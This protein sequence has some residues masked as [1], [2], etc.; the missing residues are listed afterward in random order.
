MKPSPSERGRKVASTV[1]LSLLLFSAVI[2]AIIVSIPVGGTTPFVSND[3]RVDPAYTNAKVASTTA[4]Y[5]IRFTAQ[6]TGTITKISTYMGAVVGHPGLVVAIYSDDGSSNH[7]PSALL[8]LVTGGVVKPVANSFAVG[9]SGA[10]KNQWTLGT[11]VS[12]T[13]GTIYH[14]IIYSNNATASN[15]FYAPRWYP[16]NTVWINGTSN[17]N[18]GVLYSSNSGSS[19]T[20]YSSPSMEAP[21]SLLMTVGSNTNVREGNG[22]ATG[23]T[24]PVHIWGASGGVSLKQG[25]VFYVSAAMSPVAFNQISLVLAK[26]GTPADN[27]YG[28]IYSVTPSPPYAEG[29]NLTLGADL[30]DFTVAT[31]TT[32]L[33][34]CCNFGG[35]VSV[36]PAYYTASFTATTLTTGEYVFYLDSPGSTNTAYYS[37]L[38]SNGQGSDIGT[39]GTLYDGRLTYMADTSA[40][41]ANTRANL[42]P[43]VQLGID[44]PFVFGTT[45]PGTTTTSA[46][47][48]TTSSS[49]TTTT[50]SSSTTTSGTGTPPV[51]SLDPTSGSSGTTVTWAGSGFTHSGSV[52]VTVTFDGAV[53]NPPTSGA[54]AVSGTNPDEMDCHGTATSSGTAGPAAGVLAAIL[55]GRTTLSF[56]LYALD[57]ATGLDSNV[58]TFTVGATTTT[59][60]TGTTTTTTTTTTA[61]SQDSIGYIGCSETWMSVGLPTGYG[62]HAV[63]TKNLLW[64]QLAQYSGGYIGPGDKGWSNATN[65]MWTVFSNEI[66]AWGMPQ[67]VWVEA[68][69]V[70]GPDGVTIANATYAMQTF[71]QFFSILRSKVPT[72]PIYL[73]MINN[74][75]QWSPPLCARMTLSQYDT[76]DSYINHQVSIGNAYAGPVMGPL[77]ATTILTGS[78]CHPNPAGQ[79]LLGAQ[80]VQFFD[81]NW[82]PPPPANTAFISNPF[83]VNPTAT[84]TK[85]TSSSTWYDYRFTAQHSGTV[86]KASTYMTAA[87]GTGITMT[88]YS[89]DGTA[90]HYPDAALCTGTLK[91]TNANGAYAF[92][93]GSTGYQWTLGSCP[94]ITAGDIYHL[95]VSSSNASSTYFWYAR[96]YPQ[97][98][99]WVNGTSNPHRGVLVSS[100]SGSSWSAVTLGGKQSEPVYSLLF[101]NNVVEGNGYAGAATDQ[102]NAEFISGGYGGVSFKQGFTFYISG[103]M[104]PVTFDKISLVI[105]RIGTPA[106]NLYGH[107]YAITTATPYH[108]GQVLS[109]GTDYADF[110]ISGPNTTASLPT[111]PGGNNGC[112]YGSSTTTFPAWRNATFPETTL[113][114]GEYVFYLDSPGSNYATGAYALL[115]TDG[116]GADMSTAGTYFDGR[117]TYGA[118]DQSMFIAN[119]S[120][121]SAVL[122]V[123]KGVDVPFILSS[124][125]AVTVP[126]T[127][128]TANSAPG[129]HIMVSASS[130][131]VDNA[132]IAY[133]KCNGVTVDHSVSPSVTLTAN[134][135]TDTS[136]TRFRFLVSGSP[137]QYAYDSS[138]SS[139]SCSGWSLTSYHE[140]INT[141]QIMPTSPGLVWDA[142]YTEYPVGVYYGGGSTNLCTITLV[143][144]G[145]AVS[146]VGVSDYGQ[147]VSLPASFGTWT[148]TNSRIFSSITSGGNTFSTSYSV[149]T[150]ASNVMRVGLDLTNYR[151][152]PFGSQHGVNC[153]KPAN[154]SQCYNYLVHGWENSGGLAD[155]TCPNGGC[156][157][158]YFTAFQYEV[159]MPPW[160]TEGSAYV[161]NRNW[162]L[163]FIAA[164]NADDGGTRVKIF[165][166]FIPLNEFDPSLSGSFDDFLNRLGPAQDNPSVAGI[167]FRGAEDGIETGTKGINPTSCEGSSKIPAKIAY[168]PTGMD[169]YPQNTTQLT[170][171]W[172]ALQTKVNAYGYG[173][174]VSTG[175]SNMDDAACMGV[176]DFVD[177]LAQWWIQDTTIQPSVTGPPPTTSYTI[178]LNT[179]KNAITSP[180]RASSVSL[181]TV[182]GEWVAQCFIPGYIYSG[183]GCGYT[184]YGMESSL[185]GFSQGAVS[186]PSRAQ[187]WFVYGEASL[188]GDDRTVN[189]TI[190]NT[191]FL[192]WILQYATEY[193]FFTSFS[194][195]LTPTTPTDYYPSGYTK[196]PTGLYIHILGNASLDSQKPKFSQTDPVVCCGKDSYLLDGRLTSDATDAGISG[197][198]IRFYIFDYAHDRWDILN[199]S[200]STPLTATTNS[201]GWF[202][203]SSNCPTCAVIKVSSPVLPNT[204]RD[205]AYFF[206]AFL[207]DG[208][209]QASDGVLEDLPILPGSYALVIQPFKCTATYGTP[210]LTLTV[211]SGQA[212]NATTSV[213]NGVIQFFQVS[214]SGTITATNPMATAY[215]RYSFSVGGVAQSYISVSACPTGTCTLATEIDYYQ[216]SNVYAAT[217]ANAWDNALTISVSDTSFSSAGGGNILTIA[218]GGLKSISLWSDYDTLVTMENPIPDGA[219]TWVASGATT[220]TPTTGG[221]TFGVYYSCALC[222]VVTTT[223][224]SISSTII[225]TL[226]SISSFTST[227]FGTITSYTIITIPPNPF[228]L[229]YWLIPLM[230][231]GLY[232]A[233]FIGIAFGFETSEKGL[234]YL[235]LS[236]AT[237]GSLVEVVMGMMT[238]AVPVVLIVVNI[239]YSLNLADRVFN[240]V[241]RQPSPSK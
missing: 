218:G 84:T 219:N 27:L 195:A 202:G 103:A 89:D 101:S 215:T 10:V 168:G 133:Q 16:Q 91:S 193:G 158:G 197:K 130:G 78:T 76:M 205:Q 83:I 191:Q 163:N 119:P 32:T 115:Q 165:V 21:Y 9:A 43:S 139:D 164:A 25:F 141:Y 227:G 201:Q 241:T 73:S 105:G 125:A 189:Q 129:A 26:T 229:Q 69:G 203:Y 113:T 97:N 7:Y 148:A 128:S 233:F 40:F 104:S 87:V 199:S 106:D 50:T 186:Y 23:T 157:G 131:T 53:P 232:D 29:A 204:V 214:P 39:S 86:T 4:W 234:M 209:Y 153:V 95:V 236:G 230:Y 5:D 118:D 212:I 173:L 45:T 182:F 41:A 33:P 36:I 51:V 178:N 112:S 154:A 166:I 13:A 24:L 143:T 192:S 35:T 90:N 132:A 172:D 183:G 145:G 135:P 6:H 206:D 12:V 74:F 37:V 222:W 175:L 187:Y 66:A 151:M 208:A 57:Q 140:V 146:C 56:S 3:F 110:V 211:G 100:D 34:S 226:T 111:C 70:V 127:C 124:G 17:A 42:S 18:R 120:L 161:T 159:Q 174:G 171:M 63:S 71:A 2:V 117:L 107:I 137:Q 176:K 92:K 14:F 184:Q 134:E 72:A 1:V 123:E 114:A 19:W 8:G 221:N 235:I 223:I 55:T 77:T 52:T 48:T 80:L 46:S 217:P 82:T 99:V 181:G 47:T 144:G 196:V 237:F 28:H 109:L 88:L 216:L 122:S 68:C 167:G 155:G 185:Q 188:F 224:T 147:S 94:S 85:V 38:M 156:S 207:G 79:N 54:C 198:T 177:G 58:A 81:Y 44:V 75:T 31:P 136:A 152:Q 239:A 116:R 102:N 231:L 62:Y 200:G 210:T 93:S 220:F 162:L 64:P 170:T 15:Y 169:S 126:L 180:P 67:A 60:S 190:G 138:C 30:L 11:P 22:Y 150:P 108:E 240:A 49:S 96:Y 194:S 179:Y 213:C 228:Q 59:T 160:G 225:S 65:Y 121:T 61:S 20:A 238:P 142:G 149:V 98:S